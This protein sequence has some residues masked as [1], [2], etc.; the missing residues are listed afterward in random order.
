MS[1]RRPVARPVPVALGAPMVSYEDRLGATMH[2]M[3]KP[4]AKVATG[5]PYMMLQRSDAKEELTNS[6]LRNHP[7]WDRLLRLGMD[8]KKYQ[9]NRDHPLKALFSALM[10]YWDSLDPIDDNDTRTL[11]LKARV[12]QLKD[13]VHLAVTEFKRRKARDAF[14]NLYPKDFSGEL[15]LALLAI[16]RFTVYLNNEE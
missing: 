2:S 13:R 16:E 4:P 14:P 7:K 6:P 10:D 1:V 9:G 3:P 15:K 8:L 11:E 5:A 12:Q